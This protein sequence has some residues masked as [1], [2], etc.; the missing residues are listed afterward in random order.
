MKY[1]KELQLRKMSYIHAHQVLNFPLVRLF[2]WDKTPYIKRVELM[3]RVRGN[4]KGDNIVL[5]ASLRDSFL[6][7]YSIQVSSSYCAW[8]CTFALDVSFFS[9]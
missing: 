3:R 5:S 7:V 2:E 8:H 1:G 6:V 4:T 9:L